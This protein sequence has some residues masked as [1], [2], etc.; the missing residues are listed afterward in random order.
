MRSVRNR[1]IESRSRFGSAPLCGELRPGHEVHV[2]PNK[3]FTL[4]AL[5]LRMVRYRTAGE[6][7]ADLIALKRAAERA[8]S[9]LG[10]P[11]ASS[12]EFEAAVIRARRA[13]GTLPPPRARRMRSFV[14]ALTVL[15]AGIAWALLAL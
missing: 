13:Q 1:A 5:Q 3:S 11:F 10:C 7:E 4:D 9:A 15:A 14:P 6:I 8:G 12:D 2:S